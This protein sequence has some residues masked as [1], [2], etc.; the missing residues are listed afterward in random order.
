M[1]YG[2]KQPQSSVTSHDLPTCGWCLIK[3]LTQTHHPG[4][5][6]RGMMYAPVVMRMEVANTALVTE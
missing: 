6:F 5:V 2:H 4:M 1:T 3:P